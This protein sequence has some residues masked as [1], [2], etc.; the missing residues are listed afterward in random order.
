MSYPGSPA[1]QSPT[2]TLDQ[3][4]V[5]LVDVA[6][7]AGLDAGAAR[8]EGC[9]LA[10]AVAESAP[11]AAASWAA[12]VG[13][14][15]TQ[16]FFDAATRGRRWRA[17]P[18]ATLSGLV[19]QGSSHSVPYAEALARVTGD[20]GLNERPPMR[21]HV[22]R[23]P[24]TGATKKKGPPKAQPARDAAK[25][26]LENMDPA[27]KAGKA[28]ATKATKKAAAK[29]PPKSPAKSA[30]Q[31]AKKTVKK[32]VKKTAAKSARQASRARAR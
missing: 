11:G 13:G 32:T 21:T 14:A 3:A 23:D 6:E 25:Q 4:L 15:T 7:S 30:K 31:A 10:A 18:T 24:V 12:A 22:W 2:P 1:P 16:D 27:G 29:S 20:K 26:D 8:A 17:A 5:A 28:V 9:A 19:A